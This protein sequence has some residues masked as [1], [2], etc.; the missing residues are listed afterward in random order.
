VAACPFCADPVGAKKLLPEGQHHCPIC[1][2]ALD[3]EPPREPAPIMQAEAL[4]PVRQEQAI[5]PVVPELPRPRKPEL[6]PPPPVPRPRH[7]RQI[8]AIFAVAGVAVLGMV[9]FYVIKA[10]WTRW[11]APPPPEALVVALRQGGMVAPRAQEPDEWVDASANGLEI[12]DFRVQVDSVRVGQVDLTLRG[13]KTR[14][15]EQF[16]IIRLVVNDAGILFR[17]VHYEPWADQ[18]GSPSQHPPHLT[19]SANRPYV[20]K[21]FDPLAKVVGRAYEDRPIAGGRPLIEVLVYPVPPADIEYLRLNL[22]AAAFGGTGEFH[23]QIPRSMIDWPKGNA[24]Q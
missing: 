20:Q 22:P 21:A 23:F 15:R 3:Q 2:K 16:L 18:D 12:A 10:T 24:S 11:N 13:S 6:S 5:E 4:R 1:G 7:A 17:E 19:D 9:F 14:S 8:G